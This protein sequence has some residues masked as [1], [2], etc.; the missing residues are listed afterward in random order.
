MGDNSDW[1]AHCKPPVRRRRR[2]DRTV[3]STKKRAGIALAA[4]GVALVIFGV[5]W[6]TII[7]PDLKKVSDDL[8]KTVQYDGVVTMID[9]ET[10]QPLTYN[11]LVTR[12]CKAVR[13]RGDVIYIRE[14]ISFVDK[15]TG[16][17][18]ALLQESDLLAVDR[19]SRA[20]V[21]HQGDESREGLWQFPLN[22]K[23]G[24]NYPVSISGSP[25]ALEAR[26]VGQENFMGLNVLI[27]E[28]A[29]PEGGIHIP[30][31]WTTPEMWLNR[32]IRL[33]V[34]PRSGTTVH[35][36]DATQRIARIPVFDELFPQTRPIKFTNMT[37]YE[38]HLVFTNETVKQAVHDGKFYCW[39][40]PWGDTYLPWLVFGLGAIMMLFGSM[41]LIRRQLAR[42]P[43]VKPVTKETV[44]AALETEPQP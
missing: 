15:G 44:S 26:Y 38:H 18:I 17:E 5:V 1:N 39:A 25:T 6:V 14:D 19:I 13:C 12:T 36:E 24:Q 33:K 40:L 4:V 11:V 22:V 30:G 42:A 34:E 35:F 28:V 27:Y 3:T 20:N 21:P 9:P 43:V 16:Q 8:D 37:V 41:V 29:T 32:W 31:R 2:K 7:F 10:Y 23:A